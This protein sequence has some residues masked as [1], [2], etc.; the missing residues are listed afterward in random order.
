MAMAEL[1]LKLIKANNPSYK[2]PNHLDKWANE[3]RLM[4]D[5][6]HRTL[7]QI[8]YLIKWSQQDD[9][10][11]TVILSPHSLRKGFDKMVARCRQ[12]RKQRTSRGY[13]KNRY[14]SKNEAIERWLREHERE[15]SGG[16]G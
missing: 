12:E 15:T 9:F 10:W 5:R 1:L 11:S 8:E 14:Q 7:E 16:T 4:I 2:S 3:I 13:P 6:D